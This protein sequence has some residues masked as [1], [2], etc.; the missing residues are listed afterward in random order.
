MHNERASIADTEDALVA[1][2]VP[3]VPT[4]SVLYERERGIVKLGTFDGETIH[5]NPR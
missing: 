2:L 1:F 5:T 3:N 4:G